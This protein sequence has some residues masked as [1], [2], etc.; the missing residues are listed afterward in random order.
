MPNRPF[1]REGTW[2]FP[3]T[4]EELIPADHPVRYVAAFVAGLDRR[5][6]AGLGVAADGAARGAPAYHPQVLLGVW[7]YGF[8]TG[9]RS[10][11]GLE[12]ACRDQVP[13]L[14]LTGWQR[15]DHHTLWRFYRGH[16]EALRTLLTRTVRV[17]VASG[18]VDLAVQA[19]DGTRVAGSAARERTLDAAGLAD[20]LGRV[21]TAI[22]ELEAQNEGGD[23]PPP[24]GLP[25]ELARA[26]A[27]RERVLEALARVTDEDGPQRA[28]VT[29]LDAT[30][31]KARHGGFQVGYN[32]QATVA[33][34]A[35]AGAAGPGGL[36]ITAADVTTD[37]DD[38][39][40]LVPLADQAAERTGA[41]IP[42]LLADGG[43][44]SAAN[45]AACAERGQ[46][47]VM[48]DPQAPR[49]S[50]PYHKD[51]FV[52]D[53][54]TDTYTCPQGQT[55]TL[56][57]PGARAAGG[58]LIRTYRASKLAC[59]ACPV[60]AA[61]TTATTKGRSLAISPDDARLRAHRAFMATDAARDAY[62]RRKTL[63]EPAFG[64]LK[65]RQAA[66]RFLLRG[67]PNV[68]DEWTLLATAFNLRTLARLWRAA[69]PPATLPTAA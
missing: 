13:Y 49:P 46:T 22:A 52:Y 30:L 45:L 24:A 44:H 67:L 35:P 55:L 9:V 39:G 1:S 14:W 31:Q 56:H 54:T 57:A 64:I 61:C 29:D 10:S 36:L 2:L 50:Q 32:A 34:V 60:R 11:R 17:A 18:L 21:E 48:P 51:R 23:D 58:P 65:E 63:P 37:R 69:G 43:Y 62:R 33:G 3:P 26:G 25:A 6:W 40:S 38:H 8:M 66:R 68:R 4:L 59:D 12:R 41:P 42:E 15:P 20:L 5:A 53:P 16:R 7:L 47:I 19:V 28:N 27:L